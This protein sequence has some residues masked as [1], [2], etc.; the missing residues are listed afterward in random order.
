MDVDTPQVSSPNAAFP[1]RPA[2]SND[3]DVDKDYYTE[4]GLIGGTEAW[5]QMDVMNR[6]QYW[7]ERKGMNDIRKEAF[8]VLSNKLLRKKYDIAR[9]L[10]EIDN[11]TTVFRQRLSNLEVWSLVWHS[12]AIIDNY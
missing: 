7:T 12:Q 9:R 10:R 6:L 2:I 5:S 4:L 1:A 11:D 3:F 8:G